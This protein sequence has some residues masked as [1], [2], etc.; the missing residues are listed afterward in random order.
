[1][2]ETIHI[3]QKQTVESVSVLWL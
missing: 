1:L 3:F 2:Q